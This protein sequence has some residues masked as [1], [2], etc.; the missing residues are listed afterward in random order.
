[1]AEEVA[2]E[3]GLLAEH[4]KE[5]AHIMAKIAKE[6]CRCRPMGE[7]RFKQMSRLLRESGIQLKNF[8]RWSMRT[9]IG[10]SV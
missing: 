4:L 3:P 5:M 9:D 1:M 8:L 7:R 6:T 10:K 2:G